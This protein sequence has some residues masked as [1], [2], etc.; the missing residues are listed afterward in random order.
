MSKKLPWPVAGAGIEKV[1]PGKISK[2]EGNLAKN[3]VVEVD[4]RLRKKADLRSME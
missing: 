3:S 1:V 2:G 4:S